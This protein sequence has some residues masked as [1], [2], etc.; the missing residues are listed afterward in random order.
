[1]KSLTIA[2]ITGRLRPQIHWFYRSLGRQLK[3]RQV[4]I[5]VVD[6]HHGRRAEPL[7]TWDRTRA[8]TPKPNIWQGSHRVTATDW[9][10]NS[11]ARNT[12]F[13]LCQTEWIAFLDDRCVLEPTYLDAIERAMDGNYIALG[14][15]EKRVNMR[16]EDGLVVEPGETIGVDHRRKHSPRGNMSAPGSWLFGANFALPLEW[17]LDVNGFEE[18]MDG[19][20]MEDS[21]FGLMLKNRRYNLVYEPL[22]GMIEDRT[23]GETL[24]LHDVDGTM[25]R[26]DKGVSPDDKSHAALKR[27]G[28][29]D[30]TDPLWTPPLRDIRAH[31]AAGGSFPIPDPN[32]LYRDWYDGEPI[33]GI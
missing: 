7:Y 10:A 26:S 24:S 30:R 27:F 21:I 3:D 17:A 5:I 13:C 25:K 22:M 32:R 4:E 28:K 8:T 16:V 18:A 9:W 11:N 33:N 29:R 14:S 19:L 20:S 6:F 15:Y 23:L 12:A 1:M 31:L 2:Y